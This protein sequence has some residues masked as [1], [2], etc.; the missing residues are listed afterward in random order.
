MPASL[1]IGS[2]SGLCFNRLKQIVD[3][4]KSKLNMTQ[5][6]L[7]GKPHFSF[8]FSI[9]Q[10]FISAESV[11]KRNYL[12]NAEVKR[13]RQNVGRIEKIEVRYMGVPE[14]ATFVMNK[15]LSTPYNVAQRECSIAI[16]TNIH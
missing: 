1:L 10:G 7:S 9:F 12:F 13:Q 5:F 2:R 8:I 3:T 6:R 4:Q 14:D 11:Q 15:N 16:D